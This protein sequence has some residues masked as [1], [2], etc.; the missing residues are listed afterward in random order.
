MI[1]R[2]QWLGGSSFTLQGP[3]LIYFNP[4]AN[5]SPDALLA[6]VILISH[7]TYENCAPRVINNIN[8][9]ETL[10]IA[11]TQEADCL[12]G[13]N[14]QVLRPWQSVNSGRA[15][16]TAVPSHPVRSAEI[17]GSSPPAVGFMVSLDYYDIYYAGDTVLLPDTVA[18]RPDI[19]ILPVYNKQTGLL[20]IAHVV[21]VVKM[22]QP[23]WVIPS[24]WRNNGS[25]YLDVKA[26]Q[27]AVGSS[28]EVVIPVSAT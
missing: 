20:D 13:L 22:L 1:D 27:D 12:T 6:D 15:R 16:I 19:A 28:A 25:D 4:A 5:V 14:V 9:P 17:Y 10:L 8:S 2:I 3:P 24:H 26:F 18:L 11:N 21:E 7:A 23:R